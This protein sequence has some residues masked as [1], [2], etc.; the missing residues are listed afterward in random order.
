MHGRARRARDGAGGT[1]PTPAATS[2]QSKRPSSR[3]PSL[4]PQLP[5]GRSPEHG[6][7]RA[8][9]ARGRPPSPDLEYPLKRCQ[10]R[11]RLLRGHVDPCA[12][13]QVSIYVYQSKRKHECHPRSLPAFC[14]WP[15]LRSAH[16]AC[17]NCKR[18]AG[19]AEASA[20]ENAWARTLVGGWPTTPCRGEGPIVRGLVS[21]ASAPRGAARARSRGETAR[22]SVLLDFS[23]ARR[24][25]AW[26]AASVVAGAVPGATGAGVVAAVIAART[27][28]FCA[29]S[30]TPSPKE[31]SSKAAPSRSAIAA[32]PWLRSAATAASSQAASWAD[33]P[34]KAPRKLPSSSLI[35]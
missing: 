1:R 18:T 2:I 11:R 8:G 33:A 16:R 35:A 32:T 12:P 29:A 6:R 28:R 30:N 22:A 31:K 10:P 26:S 25:A 20:R 3:V 5:A 23:A 27:R 17:L 9:D 4:P 13:I 21:P 24:A 34:S 15:P 19:G 14:A 7:S